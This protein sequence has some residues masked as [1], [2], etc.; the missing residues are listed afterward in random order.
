[1]KGNAMKSI[2]QNEKECYICGA[3]NCLENHHVIHGHGL[4]PL[5]D[6]YGLTVWLCEAH[7]RGSF[8]GKEYAVHFNR[9]MDLRLKKT[10]QRAFSARYPDKDFLTIF[11]KN[12][13]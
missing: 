13:L 5:A 6:K 1:M 12:Y 11:G 4:R 3:K 7:H 9:E 8:G 10:A 2:I